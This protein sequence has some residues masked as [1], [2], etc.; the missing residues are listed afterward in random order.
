MD[1]NIEISVK[2]KTR[3]MYEF[4][5][6][7]YYLSAQGVLAVLFS[8]AVFVY[9]LI[10][11][12]T[13][14]QMTNLLLIFGALLFTVIYPFHMWQRSIQ[15]VKLSPVLS[16]AL[17]Y[18]FTSEGILISQD[19]DDV[20][21]PWEDIKKVIETRRLLL[22]YSSPKNGY[23]LPKSQYKEQCDSIKTMIKR[24]VDDE[25]CKLKLREN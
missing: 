14:D 15:L 2:L 8:V 12:K 13:N 18:T 11:H 1:K 6:R 5:M 20:L 10:S 25:V 3:H 19:N 22:V 7:H 24:E 21:F 4:Q 23:I 9:Y 16:K 17:N